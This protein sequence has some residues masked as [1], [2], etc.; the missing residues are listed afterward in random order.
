MIKF[1]K[2]NYN[3]D[4][5]KCY[6]ILNIFDNSHILNMTIRCTEKRPD[7]LIE[8]YEYRLGSPEAFFEYTKLYCMATITKIIHNREYH[9]DYVEFNNMKVTS[10][11]S[12]IHYDKAT[13]MRHLYG[14]FKNTAIITGSFNNYV[15]F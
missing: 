15:N 8:V 13:V 2:E 3:I 11:Y 6:R 9:F 1:L 14:I 7:D 12:Q 4:N 5:T 10:S